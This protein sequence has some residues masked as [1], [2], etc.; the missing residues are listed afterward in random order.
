MG[1]R[2]PLFEW[3]W[4]LGVFCVVY[5]VEPAPA[6]PSPVEI[7]AIAA[8]VLLGGLTNKSVTEI[9]KNIEER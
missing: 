2:L 5:G 3:M 1:G 4:L 9:A 8:D 7:I 6:I